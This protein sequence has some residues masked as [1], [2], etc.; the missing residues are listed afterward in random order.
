MSKLPTGWAITELQ[1]VATKVTDGTHKTPNYIN[2][3]IRFISIKNIRPYKEIN[4]GAYE[5]FIS[6]DEHAELT[7]RCNPEEGDILFPR[8]GTIG[9]A[10]IVDWSEKFSIF[11]GL[12][13]VKPNRKLV[14]P[15][16]LEHFMNSP[17]IAEYSKENA[18]GTGRMTLSL[19]A[20]KRMPV[21]L[22]PIAEQIYISQ[23]VDGLLA[24]AHTLKARID[25]IPDL[26]KRFRQAAL[27]AAVTGRL[28]EEW[29]AQNAMLMREPLSDNDKPTEIAWPEVKLG[30]VS[31][32][33]SYGSSAKS[34][35]A[36]DIPVLRM[37][38]IQHGRI[39]W[40]NLVFTSDDNE[41][42][43]YA[44]TAGDV[45]FN[46]T[47]SPELV[48]K[49]AIYK[50]E[51]PAIYAGYLIR[52]RCS[53]ILNP[54]FLTYC[55][56]SPQGR[57]YCWQV[58]TDGVSQSNINAKKLAGFRFALPTLKEQVE[59]VRRLEELFAFTAQLET[60]IA[61]AASQVDHMT[62]SILAK[63]FTGE[64]S[65]EWRAANSDLVTGE[66]SVEAVLLKA[67]AERDELGKQAKSGRKVIKNK[68]GS[69]MNKKIVK[70]VEALRQSGEPLS[71]QQLL[72]AAGYPSDSSTE[73]LEQFFLDIR[74][75][76]TRDKS[77]VIVERSDDS[78]D[79]FALAKIEKAS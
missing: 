56:N 51:R 50:G 74:E 47:N 63:A 43:K 5:R 45:L 64:L 77:I 8:I 18:T 30:D 21:L 49:T 35:P 57:N 12:G 39:E 41:I 37:G 20:S 28:T 59:I 23:K 15:K 71:G 46:R 53:E 4:W 17:A 75:S 78:Q 60:K 76:L 13:L 54:E 38:N 73:Q 7:K 22:P 14:H 6:E 67:K 26:I 72:A 24:Q 16:Y 29:R 25:A 52:V 69:A 62:Q 66:N 42:K 2:D 65:S 40:D 1:E 58:K 68:K 27:S 79:W 44:L 36:G 3:G 70:V 19:E 33:F 10:K 31:E 9:F 55:L 11:V 34:K 61:S 48:G 32:D